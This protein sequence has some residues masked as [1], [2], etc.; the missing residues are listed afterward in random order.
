MYSNNLKNKIINAA[1]REDQYSV[2]KLIHKKVKTYI[3]YAQARRKKSYTPKKWHKNMQVV[4]FFQL[5][6]F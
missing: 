6:A 1:S 2:R 4:S 5:R 3:E